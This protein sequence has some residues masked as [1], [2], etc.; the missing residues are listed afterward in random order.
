M[1]ADGGSPKGV[2][3][4]ASADGVQWPLLF[5]PSVMRAVHRWTEVADV[6]WLTTWGHQANDELRLALGLPSLLVF[7]SPPDRN[8]SSWSPSVEA[9]PN[10]ASWGEAHADP[11]QASWANPSEADRHH[12]E[13]VASMEW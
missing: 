5:S 12:G 3:A 2:R 11:S 9:G 10:R 1:S 13:Q 8:A 6:R 7:A 4:S